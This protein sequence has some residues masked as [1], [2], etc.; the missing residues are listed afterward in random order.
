M[1]VL[2]IPTINSLGAASGKPTET[3]LEETNAQWLFTEDEV[4]NPPSVQDG[5]ALADE[6]ERRS[7]G[8]N[9]IQQVGMMLKMPQITISTAAVFFHRFVMRHSLKSVKDRK[10]MHH[11][12]CTWYPY[13]WCAELTSPFLQEIAGTALLIASKTEENIRRLKDII[14]ACCRVAQKNPNLVVDEQS[15]DYWRW[16][17]TLLFNE[18][19]LLEVLCFDLTV[20]S[21]YNLLFELIKTM[22]QAFNK[23]L[24]NVAWAFVSDSTMTILCILFTPQT[25][26]ASALYFGTKVAGQDARFPEADNE[27]G[28]PW[29]V[30][31]GVTLKNIMRANIVM[32]EYF[33]TNGAK[34]S[35]GK[36]IYADMKAA[37]QEDYER[38]KPTED[39]TAQE[40]V[41]PQAKA[42]EDPDRGLKRGRDSA[43]KQNSTLR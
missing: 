10:A 37:I 30:Q 21:P 29:W 41:T 14:Y 1:P 7:K 22:K 38:Y 31:Y 17:D 40:D 2:D 19:V 26:A 35:G 6:R 24:R 39:A 36:N 27:E 11:Y 13:T 25:I 33:E 43:D 20:A 3:I 4:N 12:V 18:D 5:M 23:D 32:A 15:K 16:R 42:A 8:V 9:F 28:Q 34:L